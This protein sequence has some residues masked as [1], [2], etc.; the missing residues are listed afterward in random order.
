MSTIEVDPPVS[1]GPLASFT[2]EIPECIVNTSDTTLRR[3][4]RLCRDL[5]LPKLH[6]VVL[7]NLNLQYRAGPGKSLERLAMTTAE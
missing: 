1:L 4:H 7:L 3:V 6:T 5:D 2:Y